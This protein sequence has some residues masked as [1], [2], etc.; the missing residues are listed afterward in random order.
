MTAEMALKEYAEKR[1][2]EK[3]PEPPPS[4]S[5]AKG[6]NRSG[7][8]CVQRHNASHLHYDFRLEVGG[9]LVSWAVPKGPSLDPARKALAMKVE[10]HPFDYGTFEGNIPK[11]SYGG[12]S[13]MLWDKGTFEVIGEPG[14]HGQLERGDFKFE[15]H[16]TKLNG[17]FA[18]VRMKKSAK[19]NEW[20]LIKKQDEHVVP[21]YDIEKF[22]WSVATKR[23]QQEI[24]DEVVPVQVLDLKGAHKSG[25]LADPDAMLAT[26]ATN[27]PRGAHWLYEIKWDGVRAL[28][29]IK[30]GKLEIQ[31]RRGNRCERQYPELA[32]LPKHVNAETAWLDGEICVLDEKGRSRFE[33][34][35]PR[36][37][38]SASAAPRLAET[39][40]VTLFLFDVLYLDGYDVRGVALEDR[41][42]LLNSIV[43][44]NQHIRL[45]ESFETDGEQMFEAAR[46]M[47]L[48][49]I[50][51]KDRRSQYV[52]TRT[53]H[54]LKLKVQNEQEFV[55]AGFTDGERDYFGALV[56]A[57]EKEGK[58]VHA[59]QVGTGFD[60]KLMKAIHGRLK[61]LITKTCPIRP[62]PKL[63]DPVTWVRPELVCQ[64]RF[65]DWTQDGML[66]APV[67]VALR[68]D[69]PAEE[70]VREEV[71][72]TPSLNLTGKEAAVS[73]EGHS[74]KFTNL[75]KVFFPK[76]GWKKRDL[77]LFYNDVADFLV[78]HLQGRPLSMKR[79]PNGIA[80]DF[81]FQ[82]NAGSHFPSWIYLE[83][84]VEHDPPKTNHYPVANDRA[85]LLYLVNL[86]CI[87]HNPWMSRVGSLQHPDWVLL[88]LDPVQV[89]YDKIVE[90]AQ[91]I[92][93]ILDELGLKGYPKT[94]GGDGMHIYIPVEPVYS[95]E[96]VRGFAEIL[97]H[98]AV[99]R[100]PS[101][102]TTPRSVEKRKK[103]RV[104]FDYLQIGTGK[105]I[106]APYV[107]RAYD[108]APVATPLNWKEVKAGL[109]P[110]DFRIDNAVAR[111]KRV[112][113]LFAPV[114]AGGQRLE[115]A[116]K[117][118]QPSEEEHPRT[119]TRRKK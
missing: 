31:T 93:E 70:V 58:W 15:L 68:D 74:L 100:A 81:F 87:D 30:D 90:A 49:G 34:I 41:K 45:S 26:A 17:S 76:D 82:K 50:L 86:G 84:I 85:S 102:F 79:Y 2:F 113:D 14:A 13:V 91:L 61:P 78:P 48:E 46:Q 28:C 22:A 109:R 27:P 35:Q 66:R 51:A 18:I 10:D 5:K 55:I 104:Y 12:G 75:D 40:P 88:D 116:L 99:D 98:L 114:L 62:V 73:I 6:D 23:T 67:F 119:A 33:L 52:S 64:I 44:P 47:G 101:L 38:A 56:I 96:Q 105:T 37:G 115:T 117:R 92:R 36:I 20:L 94:T 39:S 16:G 53:S 19:G 29:R 24:A 103:D 97:T 11:G 63:K 42:R 32:D 69:K 112:G 72:A 106:S 108:G 80:E 8:F 71:P 43:T 65:L 59:G 111:F 57:Y 77:L 118:L 1:N 7:F 25:L 54:W 95:Y 3:T 9:V 110:A 4:H 60:Q 21:D 107:V 83:P 89:S